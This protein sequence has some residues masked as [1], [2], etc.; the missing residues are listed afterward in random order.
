[1]T[2]PDSFSADLMS[3]SDVYHEYP[4]NKPAHFVSKLM[5]T[6][7]VGEGWEACITHISFPATWMNLKRTASF[8][9]YDI[10]DTTIVPET[11]SLPPD[12]YG[13]AKAAVAKINV[14]LREYCVRKRTH[15]CK[16]EMIYDNLRG[17]VSITAH[18]LNL[19]LIA[20]F[21]EDLMFELGF[22]ADNVETLMTKSGQYVI[23]RTEYT[24]EQMRELNT[25]M[26]RYT[27]NWKKDKN[28]YAL[29][30]KDKVIGK[31]PNGFKVFNQMHVYSDL[32]KWSNIGSTMAPHMGMVPISDMTFGNEVVSVLY[33]LD[34]KPLAKNNISTIEIRLA[35]EFGE[36]VAFNYGTVMVAVK[37]RRKGLRL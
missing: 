18:S 23:R 5:E 14:Q 15:A 30:N 37:F 36:D 34:W 9:I 11:I 4:Q 12:N 29:L 6:L 10:D 27:E 22:E 21:E 31:M 25:N 20:S 26:V 17:T 8:T 13:G 7:P 28:I 1:M 2:Q 3:N 32:V 35:N 33:P 19:M 24:E 16:L